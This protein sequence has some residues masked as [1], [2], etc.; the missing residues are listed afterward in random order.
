VSIGSE[1]SG[2][3]RDVR[4]EH[5]VFMATQCVS[6]FV[7]QLLQCTALC[8]CFRGR[9]GFNVKTGRGRGGEVC[10]IV[11]AHNVVALAYAEARQCLKHFHL[12]KAI[13]PQVIRINMYYA[14]QPSPGPP[15][16]TPRFHNMRIMNVTGATAP[17]CCCH[18]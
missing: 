7:E 2:S 16:T 10:N 14:S 15:D 12:L 1:M 18:C 17:A 8:S 5:N 6:M 4:I 13:A 11:F 3:V 9:Y